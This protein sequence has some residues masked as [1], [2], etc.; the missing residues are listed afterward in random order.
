MLVKVRKGWE[1]PESA[2]TPRDVFINRRHFVAALAAAG[3]TMTLPIRAAWADEDDPSAHLYPV[4]RNDAFDA[5]RPV[6]PR[7][8]VESYNNFYEFGGSKNIVRQAQA[9]PIRPWEIAIDGEVEEPF[10]IAID[11]LLGKMPLEERVYRLRCVEAWS[12]VVPWSGFQLSHLMDLARPLSTAKYIRMETFFD[13]EI[14]PGQRAPRFGLGRMWPWPYTEGL[15]MAEAANELSF[16]VTG[17]YGE[18]VKKQN[19]APLRLHVPWKY[20]FKS[21]KSIVRISFVRE[22]PLTFWAESGPT[23]YGFWANVNPDVPHPR[24]SQAQERVL[25]TNELIPTEIFNGYGEHVA[26]LYDGLE[27]ERLFM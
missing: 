10:T 21:L 13:P 24:W 18:P 6:T 8:Y 25:G 7:R 19:G 4:V 11:D 16:M 12:M 14:A 5:G 9:L 20:G 2:A 27:G 15:T 26:H 17:A 3:A 23:E 1:L 22:R